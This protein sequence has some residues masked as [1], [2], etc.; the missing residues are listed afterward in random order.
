MKLFF[1]VKIRLADV[2][3]LYHFVYVVAEITLPEGRKSLL[4]NGESDLSQTSSIGVL[5]YTTRTD[6]TFS[7]RRCAQRIDVFLLKLRYFP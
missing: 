4:W 6:S 5:K 1:G 3:A 7:P 2:A